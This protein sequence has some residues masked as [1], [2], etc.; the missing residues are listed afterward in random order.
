[1]RRGLAFYYIN[2]ISQN[3]G[4]ETLHTYLHT[5]RETSGIFH[6]AC[7]AVTV[8]YPSGG[9]D[10][11]TRGNLFYLP[12]GCQY[13][14]TF[15]GTDG[16]MSNAQVSF[17]LKDP[18]MDTPYIFA[19]RAMLLLDE[20][21]D[22]VYQ[23]MLWIADIALNV[24]YPTFPIARAFYD[25]MDLISRRMRLPETTGE[26][27]SKVMPAI[28]Y[29]EKHITDNTPVSD[30]ARLCAMC[31]SSFRRGFHAA[32]GM[33]PI[34]YRQ[35][36]RLKKLKSLVRLSPDISARELVEKLGF[37]DVS[38]LYKAFERETGMSLGR[39]RASC[40]EE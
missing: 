1:M 2:G 34:A 22:A 16:K 18:V 39:Y 35:S 10:V 13:S 20:T 19:D 9:S 8:R 4:D 11:F 23:N 15:A 32:T 36:L 7:A 17:K 24:L 31:E 26:G 6:V 33:S 25:M 21:P 5:P 27:A 3:F 40:K 30:L 37:C 12:Q 29:M 28:Y 14:L 38:Y